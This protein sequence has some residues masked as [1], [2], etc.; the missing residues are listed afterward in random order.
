MDVQTVVTFVRLM[1]EHPN[2]KKDKKL[3]KRVLDKNVDYTFK[4]RK[5]ELFKS[6]K[7]SENKLLEC[8]DIYQKFVKENQEELFS[9]ESSSEEIADKLCEAFGIALKEAEG[10]DESRDQ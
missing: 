9:S 7:D 3:F 4:I 2:L 5:Q 10:E 6:L 8:F 1:N